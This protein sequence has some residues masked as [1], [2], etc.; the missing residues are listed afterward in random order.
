MNR[1]DVSYRRN[2]DFVFRTINDE[3]I[4]VPI[5]GN[6]GDMGCIYNL[7]EVGAFVWDH[8]DGKRP[9]ADIKN[10]IIEEFDVSSDQAEKDVRDFVIQLEEID[11]VVKV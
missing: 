4:L 8:L 10:M 3:T 2:E 7:N 6:V 5:R 9:L 1:L 11:A